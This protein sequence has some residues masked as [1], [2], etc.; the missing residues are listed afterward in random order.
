MEKEGKEVNSHYCSRVRSFYV[1]RNI[2]LYFKS[3]HI[4]M[5]DRVENVNYTL[6]DEDNELN[7]RVLWT[8]V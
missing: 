1:G 7:F 8:N 6:V 5:I 2:W 3:F 4:N